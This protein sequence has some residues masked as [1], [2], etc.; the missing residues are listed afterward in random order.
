[1]SYT[2]ITRP[3]LSVAE[4]AGAEALLA[5]C[6]ETERPRLPE[7]A[8]L[9]GY[10]LAYAADTLA[11]LA[12]LEDLGGIEVGCLVH[13]AQRRRGIGRAL[14]AATRD[15]LRARGLTRCL[16]VANGASASAAPFCAAVGAACCMAEY[17]LDLDETRVPPP[18]EWSPPLDLRPATFDDVPDIARMSSAAFADAGEARHEQVLGRF[19]PGSQYI[20][21]RR[22]AEAI[23]VI[24]VVDDVDAVYLASFAVA[25]AHQ[26]QGYGRQ[27]LARTVAQ[28]LDQPARPIALEVATDNQRALAL[29]ESCGFVVTTRFD[30]YELTWERASDE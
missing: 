19:R 24:R 25:P 11:G 8:S 14:V 1:M 27:I 23:G 22:G 13:P 26:G 30:Y 28:L 18:R 15:E 9:A 7:P 10:L 5:A 4:R 21:A 6:P 16:L 2:I 17:R 29:Y 20:I 12:S 3:T